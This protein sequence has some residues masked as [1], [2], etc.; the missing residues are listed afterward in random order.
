MFA[1]AMTQSIDGSAS[2]VTNAA[3]W[4]KQDQLDYIDIF[5]VV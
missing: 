1:I 3:L 4:D 2:M 5:A